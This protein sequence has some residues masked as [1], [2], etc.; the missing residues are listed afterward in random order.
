[1]TNDKKKIGTIKWS[2]T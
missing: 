1:L 2:F